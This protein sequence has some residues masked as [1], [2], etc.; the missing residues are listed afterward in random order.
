M[1]GRFD[2]AQVDDDKI[3]PGVV[4]PIPRDQVQEVRVVGPAAA[5]AQR[6]IAG[7]EHWLVDGLEKFAVERLQVLVDRLVRPAPAVELCCRFEQEAF[8]DE[9]ISAVLR[10][11]AAV[12][13]FSQ[14]V[15]RARPPMELRYLRDVADDKGLDWEYT[16][17]VLSSRDLDE[18]MRQGW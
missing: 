12:R 4:G 16:E 10:D 9:W 2:V 18:W 13:N 8:E 17:R 5:L 14:R 6:P 15:E 7:A 11:R 3:P 1:S